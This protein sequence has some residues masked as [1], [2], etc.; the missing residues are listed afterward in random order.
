MRARLEPSRPGEPSTGNASDSASTPT[1]PSS[2][3]FKVPLK[4][5]IKGELKIISGKVSRNEAKV[6]QGIALKTGQD[7]TSPT[8]HKH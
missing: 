1:S 3:R 2:S 4:D 6:E 5:K 7:P 8:T